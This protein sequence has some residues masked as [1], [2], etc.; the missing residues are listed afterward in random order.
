MWMPLRPGWSVQSELKTISGFWAKEENGLSI[1]VR[2]LKAALFVLQ[3]HTPSTANSTINLYTNNV[4]ALKHARNQ[5]NLS[6]RLGISDS[7]A[8]Q[9]VQ[10][11]DS[12]SAHAGCDQHPSRSIEQTHN[13]FIRMEITNKVISADSTRYRRLCSP[14]QQSIAEILEFTLG[15]SS[16]SSG[17]ISAALA[18]KGPLLYP[19]W[20]LIPKILHMFK[21]QK[22]QEAYL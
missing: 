11:Q 15:S 16:N 6:T 3:L 18:K 19:P 20:K 13:I 4:T 17:R 7:R 22:V 5:L 9:S 21:R 2:E 8:H 14:S 12:L 1:N 10:P